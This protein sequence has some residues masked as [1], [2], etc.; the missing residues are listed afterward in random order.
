M[1]LAFGEEPNFQGDRVS[2]IIFLLKHLN[3]RITKIYT[4]RKDLS[5]DES[6]M[7]WRGRLVVRQY[8]KNKR[9]MG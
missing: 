1:I 6:M 2:K 5:L 4:P 7:L 8:I 9:H 3:N